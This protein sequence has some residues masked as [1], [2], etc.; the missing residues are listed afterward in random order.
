VLYRDLARHYGLDHLISEILTVPMEYPDPGLLARLMSTDPSR[1]CE[2][3]L[4]RHRAVLD[5]AALDLARGALERGACYLGA[6]CAR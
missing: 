6:H 3:V 4:Q 1:G 5:G 2:M